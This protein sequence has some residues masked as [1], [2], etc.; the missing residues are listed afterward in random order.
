LLEEKDTV[1]DALRAQLRAAG[2]PSTGGG[3]SRGGGG[4]GGGGSPPRRASS[5]AAGGGGGH[6]RSPSW[7]MGLMSPAFS[8]AGTGAGAG[9]PQPPGPSPLGGGSGA[10]RASDAGAS[11]R[12]PRVQHLQPPPE[13]TAH[14]EPSPV[15][16]D[17][18][19]A[20]HAVLPP[21][22]LPLST[23]R[24][25]NDEGPLSPGNNSGSGGVPE[26]PAA[27]RRRLAELEAQAKQW[28]SA[29]DEADRRLR[30]SLDEVARLEGVGQI[31]DRDAL[32][33]RSVIVS[34]FEAGELPKDGSMFGVLSRL[35]HF[36]PQEME[37]I[38]QHA[39]AK[40]GPGKGGGGK[41]GAAASPAR[42]G[43]RPR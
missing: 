20:A 28:R 3:L 16:D 15:P 41:G 42:L 10:P 34:G 11:P 6:S 24:L 13:I 9:A 1:I 33:L 21:L 38:R 30:A 8:G 5:H 43:G 2:L 18:R 26:G 32:Y 17:P 39:A 4:G 22:S 36:T 19:H 35:L 7:G 14:E 31:T 27:V 29:Y 25:S 40:G 37:R 23:L 12:A